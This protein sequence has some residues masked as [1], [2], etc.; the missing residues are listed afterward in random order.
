MRSQTITFT[1]LVSLGNKYSRTN[2]DSV[3]YY[4]DLALLLA[5]KDMNDL[6]LAEI[7]MV[8]G[9]DEFILGNYA[10]TLDHY[11]R[12][13]MILENP[14]KF[15]EG[16]IQVKIL[17]SKLY[18]RFGTLFG[19]LS[20]YPRSLEFLY[21]SCSILKDLGDKDQLLRAYNNIGYVYKN[22]GE[23]NKSLEFFSKA[24]ALAKELKLRAGINKILGGIAE[25]YMNKNECSKARMYYL[26]AFTICEETG[27][28]SGAAF[29]LT[30]VGRT[31]ECVNDYKKAL[32]FYNKA[33]ENAKKSGDKEKES[34]A[35]TCISNG[36][37]Q[38]KKYDL[39]EN[40]I[41]KSIVIASTLGDKF[42]LSD[43]YYN[44][45]VIFEKTGR[46][47]LA[48]EY[49]KRYEFLK[50]SLFGRENLSTSLQQEFKINYEKKAAIDSVKSVAEINNSRLKLESS[51]L[52]VK[53]ERTQKLFLYGGLVLVIV[54][55]GFIF[56][57]FKITQKQ[58]L[59]IELKE[60]ETQQQKHVIEEKQ[61]EILDSINYAKRIQYTLLAH[62]EFLINN[63]PDHFVYFNPKDIVSGDF[64]WATKQEDK[65]YLAVCDST[66]HG[67]PGA[68]MSLLNIGFLAEAINEKVIERPNKVFDFVRERL[69]NTIS[70]DGQKD[71]FD[72]ILICIDQKKNEI[73]YAAANN[74]PILIQ[75]GILK[76]LEADR[77][78]VGVG[79]RKQNFTIQTVSMNPGDTLYLYTDGYA[80]QFG[81]PKGKKFKYKQLNDLLVNLS[82]KSL[83]EQK[84]NLK[85]T[86]EYWRGDLEQVDDIC[87][88]G[89]KL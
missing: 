75:N 42:K 71:G 76:E 31:Y 63:L 30:G 50:D 70:K 68:F 2:S 16:N 73:T 52:K 35:L 46:Y 9:N 87:V 77:M 41:K 36:Y 84:S 72:G 19:S 20:D 14:R 82:V 78:P 58:K 86:F 59:V 18:G 38:L 25:V 11:E 81:G 12:A 3:A 45:S 24:L 15:K 55:A 26:E 23:N 49:F 69:T 60:K 43:C 7:L 80:D 17:K 88:I 89:I 62:D 6:Q 44:L 54:F 74:K 22:L 32:S 61:K 51:E 85:S 64:Y 53:Q 4:H 33:L 57:R 47:K 66:G 1:E 13:K 37:S 5:Q 27:D 8:I 83:N 40:Y 10:I 39:A 28:I 21:K 56:N 48:L 79:E 67:V 65:F 29:D 34:L